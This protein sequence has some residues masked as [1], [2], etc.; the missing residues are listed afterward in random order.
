MSLNVGDLAPDFT[1]SDQDG[2]LISLSQFRRQTVVLYFYPRDHTPGCTKE[3]CG[4]RDVYADYQGNNIIVLGISTD[5]PKS[6]TKFINK[7]HLPFPLL[8][9]PDGKVATLY[10]SYGLKKFMGRE[11]MGIYRQTFIINPDGYIHKIYPKVKPESHA[12]TI[13]QDLSGEG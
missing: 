10:H 2:N 9:D 4:F 12:I 3:A 1:L 11:F 13:L 8:C 7:Y 5:D 6:H